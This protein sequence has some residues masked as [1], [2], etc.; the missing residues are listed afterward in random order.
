MEEDGIPLF[1]LRPHV[2]VFHEVIVGLADWLLAQFSPGNFFSGID[3]S[4]DSI[5]ATGYEQ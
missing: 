4:V 2:S 3:S 1:S 5:D